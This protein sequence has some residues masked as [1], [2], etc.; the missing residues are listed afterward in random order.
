MHPPTPPDEPASELVERVAAELREPV[1]LSPAFEA[2]VM[3]RVRRRSGRRLLDWLVEPRLLP[4][5]PLAGLAA[6]AILVVIV[7]LTATAI[8][9]AMSGNLATA[10]AAAP[11]TLAS[12]D[13][14]VVRFVLAAPGAAQ[15][16]LVGDFNGWDTSVTPLRPVGTGGVWSV[17]VPLARGHHEYAF[18]VDGREWRPDPA[19]P[20]AASENFGQPSSIIVVGA[21]AS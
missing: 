7:A 3:A 11:S 12:N 13:V 10:P 17:E 14:Q 20:R 15:V 19:A 2:R 5:S 6:A 18:V 4:V 9:R 16:A 21:R 1:E 8:D